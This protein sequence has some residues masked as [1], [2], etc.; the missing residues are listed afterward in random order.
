MPRKKKAAAPVAKKPVEKKIVIT[1][2]QLELLND[3]Y[4]SLT[5]AKSMT[6][7]IGNQ[8]NMTIN[9]AGWLAGRV[10]SIVD[11]VKDELNTL[12]QELDPDTDE[13]EDLTW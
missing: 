11:T 12:I 6:F 3:L 9:Q 13:D 7:D 8:E 10:Y 4:Y 1:K 5:G 2:E